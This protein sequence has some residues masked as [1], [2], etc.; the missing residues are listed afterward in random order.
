MRKTNFCR[1]GHEL[2]GDNVR[3]RLDRNGARECRV[4]QKIGREA[5]N[6]RKPLY[7]VWKTMIRRC[8][9]PTFKEWYLYGGKGISVCKRW[10]L[11]YD[12]F[13]ADMGARPEGTTLERNNGNKDYKPSNCRWATPKEQARN[14]SRNHKFEHAGLNLTIAEW[15]ERAGLKYM[16]LFQRLKRGWPIEKALNPRLVERYERAITERDSEGKIIKSAAS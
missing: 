15:A 5:F 10:L 6:A 1:N 16:T 13:C 11:S 7:D 2:I 9:D 8:V 4:C 3:I 14:M 12:N